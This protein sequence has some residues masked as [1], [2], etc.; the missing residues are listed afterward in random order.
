MITNKKNTIADFFAY[1]ETLPN[2]VTVLNVLKT[3]NGSKSQ[4]D[5]LLLK[6]KKQALKSLDYI[7]FGYNTFDK[8]LK[9]T[10]YTKARYYLSA[11]QSNLLL[12][13]ELKYLNE[14]RVKEVYNNLDD[15][16]KTINSLIRKIDEKHAKQ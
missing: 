3:I 2:I 11:T 9:K 16:I 7:S 10:M 14:D 8:L 4:D 15:N 5:Y 12:L 6:T 1:N 13:I